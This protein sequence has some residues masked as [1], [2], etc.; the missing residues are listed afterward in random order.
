MNELDFGK[1]TAVITGGAAGIGFA[2]AD[3]DSIDVRV[4]DNDAFPAADAAQDI[5]HLVKTDF[6]EA[7]LLRNSYRYEDCERIL[8]GGE[9]AIP[10]EIDLA[11]ER[12]RCSLLVRPTR[13][14][15]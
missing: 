12:L 2:I 9:R 13:L 4:I 11:A 14:D 5:A 10:S 6:L 1:R 3:A 7:E 8:L 15:A